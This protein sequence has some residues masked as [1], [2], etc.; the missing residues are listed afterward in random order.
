MWKLISIFI[1]RCQ[2]DWL[3][4]IQKA[5]LISYAFFLTMFLPL[6]H[7]YVSLLKLKLNQ[8]SPPPFKNTHVAKAARIN[9][10]EG[11]HGVLLVQKLNSV[12]RFCSID[13]RQMHVF[14]SWLSYTPQHTACW[15]DAKKNSTEKHV[16]VF[17]LLQ[18]F[19]WIFSSVEWTDFMYAERTEF[20][21]CCGTFKYYSKY[22][23]WFF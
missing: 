21:S 2:K 11:E 14:T 10:T 16:W 20:K 13:S 19:L 15:P 9:G 22:F 5:G 3:K 17:S 1:L 7:N 23:K 12:Q 4:L 8:I 18:K 6:P